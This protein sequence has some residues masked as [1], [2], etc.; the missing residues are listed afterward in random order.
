MSQYIW[1]VWVV[2]QEITQNKI[3]SQSQ[4]LGR[5]ENPTFSTLKLTSI[6]S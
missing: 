3:L 4:E 6:I 1:D 5:V 2:I